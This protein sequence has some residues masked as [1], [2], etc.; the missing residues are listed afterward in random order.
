MASRQSIAEAL[1]D[2]ADDAGVE[3]YE[4]GGVL[5]TVQR[6][7]CV[8]DGI[9][10]VQTILGGQTTIEINVPG[11]GLTTVSPGDLNA[12]N[13]RQPPGCSPSPSGRSS[14]GRGQGPRSAATR[15]AGTRRLHPPTGCS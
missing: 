14:H 10:C 9:E 1:N 2:V 7:D 13:M 5:T 6:V 8:G 15:A 11:G 3:F 12:T 4:E